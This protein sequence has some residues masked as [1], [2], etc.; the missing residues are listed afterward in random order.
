MQTTLG[1][2]ILAGALLAGGCASH[3]STGEKPAADN[4]GAAKA[5]ARLDEE[6]AAAAAKRDVK[7]VVSYYAADGIAYPPGEPACVGTAALEKV[8]AGYFK[9]PNFSVSWTPVDARVAAS[10]DLGYTVGTYKVVVKG[11]APGGKDYVE[12]GKTLCVWQRQADGSWKALRDMWNAD[13]K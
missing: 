13:S 7:K 9:D 4:S 1:S 2:V 10:G 3:T 8:W 11:A 12:I 6:W 5:L